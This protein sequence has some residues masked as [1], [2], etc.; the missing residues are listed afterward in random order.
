MTKIGRNQ[1]CPCGSGKKYKHCCID[2]LISDSPSV[3]IRDELDVLMEKG[4]FHLQNNETAMACDAWLELWNS[5]KSRF[6][7]EFRDVQEAETVFS[8]CEL[9]YNWCQ[10]LEIELRNAGT[11]SLDYYHKRIAYCREFCSIFPESD[12]LLMHNMKKA[13][14]E[15]HFALGNIIEGEKCFIKLIEQYPRNIWAYIGWGDMYLWP[16]KEE[17]N[18]N[19]EKA[20]QIYRMALG[21]NIGEEGYLI[22]RLNEL[23]KEKEKNA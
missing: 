23:E 14:S 16:I 13:I 10:D 18:P 5:L 1:P 15:S 12:E 21:I 2:K 3:K 9:I 8:G 6:K 4:V 22:D 7:S 11:D 17:V 20:E 19:Y